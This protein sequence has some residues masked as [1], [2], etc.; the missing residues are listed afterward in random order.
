MPAVETRPASTAGA[1]WVC[2]HCK[3]EWV[4]RKPYPPV[5]C[6]K[7]RKYRP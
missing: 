5:V 7:C 6:P 4:T 1:T 3:H 2:G